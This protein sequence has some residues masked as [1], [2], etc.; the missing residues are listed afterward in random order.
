[1]LTGMTPMREIE[2][3]RPAPPPLGEAFATVLPA[4]RQGEA[5]AWERLYRELAPQIRGYLRGAGARDPDDLLGEVFLQV[6]RDLRRFD[7]DG[8]AFRAWVFT[9][10]HHRLLDDA[11][12]RGRRPVSPTAFVPEEVGGDVEDE[13]VRNLSERAIT[14]ALEAL[15]PD[16]RD[17][18]LLRV[19][20]GLTVPEIARLLDKREGAV[21]ALQRRAAGTLRKNF[22]RDGTP[23]PGSGA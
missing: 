6:V 10:A 5:W 16:Q 18:L 8:A 19:I 21:K 13:A 3:A 1:M 22:E 4:A 11:R 9:I 7:G 14:Q 15:S 20:G 17:V 23:F 12:A 2:R